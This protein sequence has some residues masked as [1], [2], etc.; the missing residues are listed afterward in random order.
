MGEFFSFIF[1]PVPRFTGS[2]A[3]NGVV[4]SDWRRVLSSNAF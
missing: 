4:I 3:T 2:S 1:L